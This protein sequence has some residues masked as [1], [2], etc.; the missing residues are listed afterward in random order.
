VGSYS[1]VVWGASAKHSRGQ[2]V[3]LDHVLEDEDGKTFHSFMVYMLP[4]ILPA[5]RTHCQKVI[6]SHVI[7][8]LYKNHFC[9]RYMTDKRKNAQANPTAQYTLVNI[10]GK[11]AIVGGADLFVNPS[12]S[13]QVK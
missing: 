13:G 1:A 11:N 9:L 5:S 6:R 8:N 10:K 12:G 2:K 4:F 7:C 3:G